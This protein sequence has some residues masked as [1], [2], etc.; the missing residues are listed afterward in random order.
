MTFEDTTFEPAPPKGEKPKKV[1]VVPAEEPGEQPAAPK[2]RRKRGPNKVKAAVDPY[3]DLKQIIT[4]MKGL[5]R[6]R[7]KIALNLFSMMFD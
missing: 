1:K 3:G 2:Q 4:L 6:A 7:R 5:S